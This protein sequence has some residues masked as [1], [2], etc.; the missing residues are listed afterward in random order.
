MSGITLKQLA[1]H[2]GGTVSGDGDLVINAVAT[3]DT[4]KPD[5]ITFFSNEKY[6]PKLMTTS[7]GAVIVSQQLESPASL[8]IADDP[9]YAFMQIVVFL[10]GH[11]EH[12]AGGISPKASIAKTATVGDNCNIGEF[13][14]ISDGATIGDNCNVYP[15]VFIGPN[16]TIGSDCVI[17]PNAVVYDNIIVGDRVIIHANAAVGQDGYGFATH[18]GVHHK[19]PQIGRVVLEDDVEIGS[20]TVVERGTLDDTIIG[21]GTKVGDSVAIG[22]G[23][24]IGPHCLIVPQ[25]GIA[26]SATLGHHCVIGGQAGMVGHIRIGNMVKVGA[27]AGVTNDV[28]DG[29]TVLGSPAVDYNLKKRMW[30]AERDLPNM[31]K[32]LKVIDK[33][34]KKLE[35]ADGK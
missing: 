20:G 6:L 8:L 22:H 3:I 35:E 33:R 9:Y 7:A 29:A 17:Y 24:V 25:V 11:R 19:I 15:G 31:R 18:D 27:Q 1:E 16:T 26:G 5:E 34:L 28:P 21:K 32:N 13:A 4:A 10:H 14:V 2:V 12:K 30:A 23:A